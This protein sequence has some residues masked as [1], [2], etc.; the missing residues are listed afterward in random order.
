[1]YALEDDTGRRRV[2]MDAGGRPV[3]HGPVVGYVLDGRRVWLGRFAEI[4][5]EEGLMTAVFGGSRRA[6]GGLGVDAPLAL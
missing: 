1:M 2:V 4:C 3:L 5:D 6:R